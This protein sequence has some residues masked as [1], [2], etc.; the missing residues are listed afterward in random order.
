MQNMIK[1]SELT[2]EALEKI[3]KDGALS[4]FL[5][6]ASKDNIRELFRKDK[7]SGFNSG[8]FQLIK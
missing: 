3:L 4:A 5:G 6:D 1:L 8:M 2:E 7:A